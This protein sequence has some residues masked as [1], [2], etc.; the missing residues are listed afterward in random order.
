MSATAQRQYVVRDFSLDG[1]LIN[2]DRHVDRVPGVG[3]YGLGAQLRRH[4]FTFAY[5][6]DTRSREYTTGPAHHTYSSMIV[7]MER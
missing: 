6:M 2:P 1:T 7:S 5:S 3:E 4:R